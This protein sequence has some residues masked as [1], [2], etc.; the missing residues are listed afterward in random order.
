MRDNRKGGREVFQNTLQLSFFE[1]LLDTETE[2]RHLKHYQRTYP[3]KLQ[4]EKKM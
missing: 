2:S 4:V 1:G 3:L